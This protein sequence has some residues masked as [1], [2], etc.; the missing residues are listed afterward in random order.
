MELNDSPE[1]AGCSI[2]KHLS[3]REYASQKFGW[4]ENDTSLPA[5]AGNL[6]VILDV[7]PDSQ[8]AKQLWQCPECSTYFLYETTY[9]FLVNGSEDEQSLTR[10]PGEVAQKILNTT[11]NEQ[12]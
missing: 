1:Q 9:E 10:I 8:R 7:Q 4:E 11:S 2:C 3:D 5:A 6:V 12:Q